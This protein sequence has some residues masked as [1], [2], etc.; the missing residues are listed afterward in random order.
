M[1]KVGHSAA[2]PGACLLRRK[3]SRG[4]RLYQLFCNDLG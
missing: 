2:L 3:V 4:V 1:K